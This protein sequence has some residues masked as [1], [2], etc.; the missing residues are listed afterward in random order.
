MEPKVISCEYRMCKLMV[1][2]KCT[3][4]E[5]VIS[6]EGKCGSWDSHEITDY[7]G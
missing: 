1:D 7:I 6:T 2:G 4:D 5:V 3:A